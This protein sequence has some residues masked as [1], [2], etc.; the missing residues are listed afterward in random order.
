[1]SMVRLILW[2]LILCVLPSVLAAETV[3]LASPDSALKIVLRCEDNLS[4]S[5]YYKNTE[6]VKPSTIALELTD[7]TLG[8]QPKLKEKAER[9]ISATLYPLYG[10]SASL[11]DE[12]NELRVDFEGDY[13][14]VIRAYNEGVAYRFVSRFS[15]TVTV[16]N[17]VAEFNIV[18]NPAVIF[19]ETNTLTSWE[20]M[21]I[22]YADLSAV[23]EG[24]RAI[25]PVL[26]SYPDK[27]K[28][29][30]AESDLWDYPGMYITKTKSGFHGDFARFPTKTVLGSWGDFVPVVQERADYLAK[31]SG[32]REF[33]WR[34]IIVTDDDRTLLTNELVYKLAKPQVE[35]DF[36]WV[37]P[38]K[39]AWE[40][41]HDAML[42][43][44]DIPSGMGNRNTALYKHYIDF[45][46]E[47]KL[48]YVMI[49]AGWSNNH[50]LYKV[51]PKVDIREVIN[52]GKSKNVDVFLWCVA[53]TLMKDLDGY[54]AMMSEWGAAGIKVDFF[55]SDNQIIM[56]WHEAIAKKAAQ[57]KLMVNFHGCS[58]PTGMQRTYPN[59][60]NYEA[61]RGGECAKWDSTAN[62]KHHVTIPF[63]RMLAGSIDYTA[64]SMRNR[65]LQGFRPLDP[66]MP[67][68]LGTRAHELSMFIV[69]DQY[70]AMLCDSPSE[71]RKYP[72]ILR[73]LSSVPVTYDET[74]VLDATVGEFIL[75][76]KRR[77]A[78]WYVGGMTDWTARSM[79]VDCS[80]LAKDAKYT[81]EIYRDGNDA[82]TNAEQYIYEEKTVDSDTVLDIACAAGGGFA[83]RIYPVENPGVNAPVPS[84]YPS[85]WQSE[86]IARK[87]GMF[88]HF[89]INTFHNEEWTDGSKPASSYAPTTIDA[90]QWVRVAKEAG[91]KYIILVTKHHEGFCLWD[92]KYTE[93]DVA[94]SGNKTDV[95]EAVAKECAEQGIGLGLYYSLWD[96]K[97]NADTGNPALDA[98]YNTYVTGQLN[99]LLDI[100]Q[101]HT[102]VV[103]F[104]F[105][106]SWE[107]TAG[108]W[109]LPMIY[110]TIK[111]KAP[112]CQIGINWS[113][114]MPGNVEQAANPSDQKEGF[115][116]RYFPGDF[117]LGDPLLPATP[118]PKRFIHEG[119]VYY[120]P[121][122]TTVV[123][124][125]RWFYH[126]EDKEYKSIDELE[127]LFRIATAQDNILILNAPPNRE[128]RIRDKDVE[129]L[130][131]LRDRVGLK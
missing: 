65:T 75:L 34:V 20:L 107:K 71:Y 96:R 8:S 38:G 102:K 106:G 7:G 129:V 93:Y 63:T 28:L 62:P 36:S 119:A 73:F 120:M 79:T 56:Q 9:S 54:M 121:W 90:K 21:Y 14:V 111:A 131:A 52:Y 11:K 53:T 33:P 18:G 95:V 97:E 42:P 101:K 91:M 17:E 4:Y 45:A 39:A 55:D 100:V 47:N 94:S 130:N 46:A 126:T 110:R 116:I 124:S 82:N 24:K 13:S 76:A 122:E 92:S 78:E 113:I 2:N 117:R 112:Q 98:G 81:A 61:V 115:P 51:N 128:G 86:Q 87:Y 35:G 49:D 77:G 31:T 85:L 37:K 64:G 72:D 66:G 74:R 84:A 23:A 118:D 88:I 40:W 83:I 16:K 59:I 103:E 80:F 123:L 19:P 3:E 57:Y 43:S 26:F 105:D 108:R 104:W 125:Q 1:M 10:K 5:V 114:G 44:A 15:E 50:D 89:G 25:T 6:V 12:Y 60:I 127:N 27:V 69:F 41:W 22:D 32:T 67:L 68:T 99:E 58:K 29:L 109:D 70:F 48:E 30:I